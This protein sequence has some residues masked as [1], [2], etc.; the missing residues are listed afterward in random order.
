MRVPNDSEKLTLRLTVDDLGMVWVLP[1]EGLP[2]SSNLTVDDFV[3]TEYLDIYPSVRVPA[4][5]HNVPML[6]SLYDFKVKERFASLEVCSPMNFDNETSAEA[7]LALFRSRRINLAP[8][9]GGWHEFSMKDWPSYAMANHLRCGLEP[10]AY[11]EQLLQVHPVWPYLSF[12]EN[13]DLESCTRLFA[14]LLDPRWFID[15]YGDPDNHWRLLNYLGVVDKVSDD[16]KL[17]QS[18]FRIVLD[19]WQKR[20]GKII[21]ATPRNFLWRTWKQKHGGL[22]GCR[23]GSRLF[24]DYLRTTWTHVMSNGPQSTLLFVPDYFF[25]SQDEMIALCDHLKRYI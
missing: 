3:K 7:D 15:P 11:T 22:D 21:Q 13:L 9:I 20:S 25:N 2:R 10:G 14:L 5:S 23:A 16:D 24:I 19:C 17:R 12:I 4:F 6:I 18:R 8:S 1:G